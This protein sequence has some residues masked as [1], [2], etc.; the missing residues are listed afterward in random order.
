ML[1]WIEG[2]EG[3]TLAGIQVFRTA[4]N[5]LEHWRLNYGLD[6]DSLKCLTGDMTRMLNGTAMYAE[7]GFYKVDESTG[8]LTHH[9]ARPVLV[10][11][12]FEDKAR[13]EAEDRR[14]EEERKKREI[15]DEPLG[16]CPKCGGE[17]VVNHPAFDGGA[18]VSCRK[19]HYAPQR[20]T[21]APTD[22]HAIYNWNRLTKESEE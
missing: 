19:C 18:Y 4:A 1:V 16:P 12:W 7:V 5:V 10:D 22:K 9:C 17:A 2:V 15:P 6:K 11:N 14:K 20:L 3:A 8:Q 13:K 21:W